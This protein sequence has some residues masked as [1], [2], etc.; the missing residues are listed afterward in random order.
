MSYYTIQAVVISLA[1]IIGIHYLITKV[2]FNEKKYKNK[3][4]K[5][6]VFKLPQEQ[7]KPI[8]EHFESKE[9]PSDNTGDLSS[10]KNDIMEFMNTNEIYQ[11]ESSSSKVE[12]SDLKKENASSNFGN[13][14]TNLD[15]FF[16]NNQLDNDSG[17]EL[18]KKE[19]PSLEPSVD[20]STKKKIELNPDQVDQSNLMKPDLW[21]YENESIMNGGSL[22][23]GLAA[24]DGCDSSLAVY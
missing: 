1:V 20:L 15:Q 2:L 23:G 12:D 5:K 24:F 11:N 21:K 8:E 10:M 16:K 18:L 9:E 19:Q 6:V 4:K 13:Q 22:G 3:M 7:E 17:P 14:Q